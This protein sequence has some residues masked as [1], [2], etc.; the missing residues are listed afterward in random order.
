M[1]CH[2][3]TLQHHN[4]SSTKCISIR[5]NEIIQYPAE[6]SGAALCHKETD[7]A[8]G[9]RTNNL[10]SGQLAAPESTI[11]TQVAR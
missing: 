3:A 8:S 7:Q 6:Q 11:W 5:I 1:Q 4:Y 9:V 10:L 2:Q